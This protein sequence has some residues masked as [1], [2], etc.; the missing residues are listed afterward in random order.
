M[1]KHELF[2]LKFFSKEYNALQLYMTW[3]GRG[4]K[5]ETQQLGNNMNIIKDSL[6]LIGNT[7]SFS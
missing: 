6:D 4:L 7:P 1:S 3:R 2:L 5:I